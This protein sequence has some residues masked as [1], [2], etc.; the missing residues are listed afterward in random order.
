MKRPWWRFWR[1]ESERNVYSCIVDFIEELECIT[2]NDTSYLVTMLD[3]KYFLESLGAVLI[4]KTS[5]GI[6]TNSPVEVEIY[7]IP[8]TSL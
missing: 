4:D 5:Y 2:Q 6:N 7:R 8:N 1:N 3:A